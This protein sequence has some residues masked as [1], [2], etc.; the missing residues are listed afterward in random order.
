ASLP[1]E[2]ADTAGE[3]AASMMDMFVPGAYPH[4]VEIATDHVLL[5]GYAF[6]DEF[7]FGLEL[8]LDGLAKSLSDAV[9]TAHRQHS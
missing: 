1:F 2:G 5:P 7:G 8:I 6:G 3:V 4:L 9:D